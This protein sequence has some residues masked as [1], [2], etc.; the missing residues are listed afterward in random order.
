[1]SGMNPAPIRPNS[2][3][4]ELPWHHLARDM[5]EVHRL[6]M[7]VGPPGCGKTAFS[8]VE[9]RSRTAA[10]AEILQGTPE[11][12]LSHLWGFFGITDS[13]THFQDGPLPRALK[14][15]GFFII[16]EF[17]LVPLEAR[18]SLLGLRG[19]AKSRI[20]RTDF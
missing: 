9:A 13:R 15:G 10:A 7:L 12:E 3:L 5:I 18:A 16:E 4:L 8:Q 14:T 19:Q 1:M 11:T 17:N 20:M 6:I 2:A